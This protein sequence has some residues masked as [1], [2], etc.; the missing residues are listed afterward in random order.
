MLAM[1]V[2]DDAGYLT[3]RGALQFFASVLAP[4]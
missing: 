3:P 4:T 2:N 1:D